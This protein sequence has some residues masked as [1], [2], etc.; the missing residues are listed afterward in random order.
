MF[1]EKS[2]AETLYASDRSSY[3]A[4][5]TARIE[6][7]YLPI[8]HRGHAFLRLVRA[9]GTTEELHGFS[10]S[11]DNGTINSMG[12]D[13]SRL[14]AEHSSDGPRL[15]DPTKEI[16]TIVEGAEG[17][18]AKI[19]ERGKKAVVDIN[20]DKKTFDYKAHD[21]AYEFGG[22]G[23]QIQ[24]SNS[25]TYTLGR[26]M[27]LDLDGVMKRAGVERKFSGWGRNLLD[28]KYDRYVAPSQLAVTQT[29]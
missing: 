6:L 20:A 27:G 14:V 8:L 18:I 29:P 3:P 15:V 26:A 9:D 1:D 5:G 12:V 4:P 28:P 16:G 7:H 21:P 25:V 2:A 19:W 11:R 24:N 13:G 10:R 22:N 23:G 17:D